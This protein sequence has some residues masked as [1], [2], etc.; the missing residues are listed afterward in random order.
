MHLLVTKLCIYE[1]TYHPSESSVRPCY[2]LEAYYSSVDI[3][4]MSTEK[5]RGR[6]RGTPAVTVHPSTPHDASTIVRHF[7]TTSDGRSMV[8]TRRI[9]VSN[10]QQPPEPSEPMISGH[11]ADGSDSFN[12]EQGFVHYIGA[13]QRKR[14]KAAVSDGTHHVRLHLTVLGTG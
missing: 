14:Y 6:P 7:G 10:E 4:P 8:S 12:N 13:T 3:H 5:R 2:V 11:A 1:C 9:I